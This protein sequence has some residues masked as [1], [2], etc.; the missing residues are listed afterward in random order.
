MAAARKDADDERAE[1]AA[2]L[3]KQIEALRGEKNAALMEVTEVLREKDEIAAKLENF[4][5]LGRRSED[6]AAEVANI[7][8]AYRRAL[9][10]GP[11]ALD[12]DDAAQRGA[13]QE[14][15]R[16]VAEVQ[17]AKIPKWAYYALGV[18]AT[19]LPRLFG[20]IL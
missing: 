19:L 1:L 13:L 2:R 16:A 4:L 5:R 7:R 20:G 8:E 15:G 14:V 10:I 18:S 6:V 17:E 12:P 11:D 3:E 9:D